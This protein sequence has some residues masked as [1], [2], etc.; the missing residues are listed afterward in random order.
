MWH[1]SERTGEW[2][3]AVKQRRKNP[4]MAPVDTFD[5]P[6]MENEYLKEVMGDS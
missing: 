3:E 6:V 5:V 1:H 4:D 2:F